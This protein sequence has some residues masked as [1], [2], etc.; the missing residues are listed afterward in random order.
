M[1]NQNDFRRP[2]RLMPQIS[3]LA[4]FEAVVRRG[5]FTAAA[6]ELALTQSAVS[7]QVSSLENS[8]GV[9]LLEKNRRRQI[10]LTASGRFYAEQVSHIL[11]SLMAAT[12]EAIALDERGQGLRLGIPPTFG[13]LWL[14]PRM[15]SFFEA[16]PDISVEFSTRI[17]SQPQTKPGAQHV[18]ID[19]ATTPGTDAVWEELF[20][21]E[22]HLVA[23]PETAE[24]LKNAE[25]PGL[26]SSH[27]LVHTSERSRSTELFADPR[28]EL[29]R[30]HPVVT[31]E[32]YTML[33]QAAVRG[34]GVALAPE[35]LMEADLAAGRLVPITEW[36]IPA[37]TT[38]YLIYDKAMRDYPPLAAFRTWLLEAVKQSQNGSLGKSEG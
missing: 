34:L 9:A 5:G 10:E 24:A 28:F 17:P 4:A 14:I 2:R 21:L 3:A 11:S 8:L 12:T 31:F 23:A 1:T 22:L 29:V 35:E 32:S 26:A 37:Q 13:S 16:H 36:S 18:L 25:R 19:F 15:T 7:R 20:C 33:L 27:L 6:E 30:S 38:G